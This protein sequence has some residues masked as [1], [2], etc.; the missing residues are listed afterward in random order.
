LETLN[1]QTNNPV[2]SLCRADEADL[3]FTSMAVA[4]ELTTPRGV[5]TVPHVKMATNGYTSALLPEFANPIVPCR[6]QV[7]VLVPHI[8]NSQERNV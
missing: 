1:L 5:I 6:G 3:S 8:W 2:M 4:W 7:A